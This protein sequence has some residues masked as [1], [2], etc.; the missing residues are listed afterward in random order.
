MVVIGVTTD[1]RLGFAILV[2]FGARRTSTSVGRAPDLWFALGDIGALVFGHPT[3]FPAIIVMQQTSRK[4][5]VGHN[6][7]QKGNAVC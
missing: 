6:S 5:R 3:T 7:G 2:A 4:V 1:I